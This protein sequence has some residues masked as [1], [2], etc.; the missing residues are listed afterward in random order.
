M[1]SGTFQCGASADDAVE[2]TSPGTTVSLTQTA[3]N[4]DS[5]TYEKMGLRFPSVSIPQGATINSAFLRVVIANSANDEP[6][7]TIWGEDTDNAAQFTTAA[8]NVSGRTKTTASVDWVSANL[9]AAGT[10]D[11]PDLSTII[12]EIVDRPGWAENNA[13]ALIL[14]TNG[15][16]SDDFAPTHYDGSSSNAPKLVVDWTEGGGGGG[17]GGSFD[18]AVFASPIFGGKVI[19]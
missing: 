11:S 9:G 2:E 15:G 7:L 6:D 16:T 1:A 4:I 12:Q 13:I 8:A 5:G 19:S 17:G 18:G 14:I 3:P 10:F